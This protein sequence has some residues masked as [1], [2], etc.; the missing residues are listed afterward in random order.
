MEEPA[1]T[2]G[3]SPPGGCQPLP[4]LAVEALGENL[5]LPA[6]A[7]WVPPARRMPRKKTVISRPK[8]VLGHSHSGNAIPAI[9][10]LLPILQFSKVALLKTS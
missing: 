7:P 2:Y 6:C 8:E 4:E 3:S 1:S 9:L 10:A 5:P